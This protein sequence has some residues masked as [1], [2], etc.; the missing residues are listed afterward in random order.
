MTFFIPGNPEEEGPFK[1]M[2][3]S[4]RKYESNYVVDIQKAEFVQTD[5][6]YRLDLKFSDHYYRQTQNAIYSLSTNPTGT[7]GKLQAPSQLPSYT[8]RLLKKT[9]PVGGVSQYSDIRSLWQPYGN[10]NT[11]NFINADIDFDAYGYGV[12]IT[13]YSF[14]YPTMQYFGSFGVWLHCAG[15]SDKWRLGYLTSRLTPMVGSCTI[16]A[17][18]SRTVSRQDRMI[19]TERRVGQ[20]RFNSSYREETLTSVEAQGYS[21]EHSLTSFRGGN[22]VVQY[23]AEA[24][25]TEPGAY[26]IAITRNAID[27][28][29]ASS[30]ISSPG[31]PIFWSVD[32]SHSK[33]NVSLAYLRIEP[34]PLSPITI[35]NDILSFEV[36]SY[37]SVSPSATANSSGQVK[38]ALQNVNG[39]TPTFAIL[40]TATTVSQ[41]HLTYDPANK[42]DASVSIVVN[43]SKDNI[44]ILQANST[45]PVR[46]LF[47]YDFRLASEPNIGFMPYAVKADID[48]GYVNYPPPILGVSSISANIVPNFSADWIPLIRSQVPQLTFDNSKSF[49]TSETITKYTD[50]FQVNRTYVSHQTVR[51]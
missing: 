41:S 49:G 17:P 38:F 30:F 39:D 46:G 40:S 34:P 4:R 22:T 1:E 37:G 32:L 20:L 43:T 11:Q 2:P 50:E 14:W 24:L 31:N 25:F 19:T 23:D 35:A 21:E 13:P 29:Y 12:G 7:G 8:I 10:F 44:A 3:P 51:S 28:S 47:A 16:I 36:A 9:V 33:P 26:L 45:F 48:G 5:S 6:G 18:T 27:N 42:A 15:R